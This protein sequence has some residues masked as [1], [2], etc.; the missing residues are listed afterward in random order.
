MRSAEFPDSGLHS[1]LTRRVIGA[2]F[3]VHRE[4]GPGFLERVYSTA[5]SI[6]LTSLGLS[7]ESEVPMNVVYKGVSVGTYFADL[8]VN[9]LVICE[10]KAVS[11]LLPEH[12]AQII[13]YLKATGMRVGLLINFGSTSVQVKRRMV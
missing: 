4:L 1:D 5:L 8:L 3:E 13:H 2:A 6:E 10:L 7:V 12:E 11:Q 9:R